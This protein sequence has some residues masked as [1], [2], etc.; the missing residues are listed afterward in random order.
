MRITLGVWFALGDPTVVSGER[1][2][3]ARTAPRRKARSSLRYFRTEYCDA[4][5]QHTN[6]RKGKTLNIMRT[7]SKARSRAAAVAVAVGLSLLAGACG[8]GGN[9]SGSSSAGGAIKLGLIAPI[10]G[11]LGST[12]GPA[13][14]QGFK[15]R[16][17]AQNEAGGVNGHQLKAVVADNASDTNN[18]TTAVQSL[19][20]QDVFAVGAFDPF[21]FAGYQPLTQQK[22]PVVGAGFGGP[23]FGDPKVTNLVS[24]WGP[25]TSDY[26]EVYSGYGELM[27]TQGVTKL[28]VLGYG[29]QPSSKGSATNFGKSAVAAG[30]EL[31]YENY[32]VPVSATDFTSIALQIKEKG[33]DGVYGAMGLGTD[34]A[35]VQA[36]DNAGVSMK[37]VVATQ[38]YEQSTLE[39][40]NVAQSAQGVIFLSHNAPFDVSSP[41]AELQDLTKHAGLE[42]L[43]SFGMNGGWIVA[44]ALIAGLEGAGEE[45]TRA[46]LLKSLRS[47]TDYD[48]Q[49]SLAGP[50]DY[51]EES[52]GHGDQ[53]LDGSRCFS[54]MKLE[55]DKF[56]PV[57]EG[58]FCGELVK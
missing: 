35:I 21:L 11:A 51:S 14:E 7:R 30:V 2:T 12:F 10:T 41:N 55:G 25:M 20:K 22:I 17:D 53:V 29:D 31:C 33:C 23:M 38:G 6:F 19:I 57:P 46:D 54:A 40:K 1:R 43:P 27:K 24:V 9:D 45:P 16:I 36:L 42:G 3:S 56:E 34:L 18:E 32:S 37:A 8:A 49:E 15:A 4:A 39:D 50:A 13:V 52:I 5:V 44:D 28:A 48:G 26:S 47:M 58:P